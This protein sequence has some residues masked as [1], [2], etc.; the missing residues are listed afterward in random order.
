MAAPTI[1]QLEAQ[2]KEQGLLLRTHEEADH[3]EVSALFAAGMR[4]YGPENGYDIRPEH[5]EWREGYIQ[6]GIEGDLSADMEACYLNPRGNFWVV[7]DEREGSKTEG[8][9]VGIVGAQ[10]PPDG[11]AK[12]DGS[13]RPQDDDGTPHRTPPCVPLAPCLR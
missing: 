3:A 9:I 2:L 8:G 13:E 4:Y 7:V 5:H 12:S 11:T 10:S 6:H 1:Q